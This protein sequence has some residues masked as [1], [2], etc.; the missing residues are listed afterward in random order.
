MALQD[1]VVR[2]QLLKIRCTDCYV[3][4]PLDPRFFYLRRGDITL[5]KLRSSL[6]CACCGSAEV[7]LSAIGGEQPT[8][9]AQDSL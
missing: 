2:G 9:W 8:S 5:A 4:T 1:I 7:E 6:V 3:E